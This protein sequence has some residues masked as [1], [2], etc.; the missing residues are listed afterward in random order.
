MAESK[1]RDYILNGKQIITEKPDFSQAD[2]TVSK[3]KLYK[4]VD[5]DGDTYYYRGA[6]E[7][8]YFKFANKFW[9]IIRINGSGSIRLIYDGSKTYANG[10]TSG[11]T[12]RCAGS[13]I[14]FNTYVGHYYGKISQ[15]AYDATHI[16]ETPSSAAEELSSWFEKIGLNSYLD[17]IDLTSGFINDRTPYERPNITTSSIPNKTSYGFGAKATYYGP[18]FRR[19]TISTPS[20]RCEYTNDLFTMVNS[21]G[22]GNQVLKHPVGLLTSD[23]A[24]YAGGSYPTENTNYYLCTGSNF[25]TMSPSSYDGTSVNMMN[26]QENGTISGNNIS[27]TSCYLRP[28]INIKGSVNLK[29]D[30]TME[31]PYEIV[32]EPIS[33]IRPFATCSDKELTQYLKMHYAGEINL[34]DY[35][36]V[37]DTRLIHLN[38]IDSPE[39]NFPERWKDQDITIVITAINYHDLVTPIN[40]KTKAIITCQTREV[41][42]NLSQGWGE[43]GTVRVNLTSNLTKPTKWSELPLRTW[44]NGDFLTTCFSKEL[45]NLIVETKH[46]RLTKY[47]LK[48]TEE[49]NDKI[50]LPSYSEIFGNVAYLNYLGNTV[51]TGQEGTQWEYYKEPSNRLKRGNNNGVPNLTGCEWWE[52]SPVSNTTDGY[53]WCSVHSDVS[54]NYGYAN[55]GYSGSSNCLAPA[56][57]LAAEPDLVIH[58]KLIKNEKLFQGIAKND[59]K[60][61]GIAHVGEIIWKY[62]EPK[63]IIK[64][65]AEASDDEIREYLDLHYSGKINIADYW[66][67]GDTRVM[68]LNAM[69]TSKGINDTHVEQ[70]MAMVIIGMNHDTLVTPINSYGKAA[71]TLQCRELLGNNG[72]LE[73]GYLSTTTTTNFSTNARRTWLNDIFV[74]SL[75]SN[76]QPLVKTIVK[77]NLANHKNNTP[78]TNTEDKAFLISVSEIYGNEKD[79]DGKDNYLGSIALEGEQYDYYKSNTR[80]KKYINNNGEAGSSTSSYWLRSPAISE[81]RFWFAFSDY[82]SSATVADFENN[83]GIA[84]SFCL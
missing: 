43:N 60:L 39:T 34:A 69:A 15:A 11:D 63:P 6:V 33:G 25:W 84:P 16:N 46:N 21:E 82:Y 83:F 19:T 65:F 37:G 78:G 38:G 79:Y 36:H 68:H 80:R 54:G 17:Y 3:G 42:N 72:V 40:N 66:H 53:R 23:E 64:P 48:T 32:K 1:A 59:K 26:I 62:E 74:N 56:F 81:N 5:N 41:L 71:I 14:K 75:P 52:S 49:V 77:K 9:R 47:N 44:L 13:P 45:Q 24:M 76:I 31:N 10:D 58:H 73:Y 35:W 70:D 61:L 51:P 28:V 18:Y 67:V 57:C 29:G 4:D 30:G 22:K 2:E 55:L 8:N 20:F 27:N 50:F 7:D 12:D